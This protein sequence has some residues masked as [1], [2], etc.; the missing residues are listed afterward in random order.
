LNHGRDCAF[1][2]DRCQKRFQRL[3]LSSGQ[4]NEGSIKAFDRPLVA[5][6]SGVNCGPEEEAVNSFTHLK[7]RLP[8]LQRCQKGLPQKYSNWTISLPTISLR[9]LLVIDLSLDALGFNL[10]AVDDGRDRSW[11][12]ERLQEWKQQQ[13]A[14]RQQQEIGSAS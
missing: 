2:G 13:E 1:E 14:R 7:R 10:W 5:F 8:H 3:S 6:R 11:N 12:E 9:R 4:P